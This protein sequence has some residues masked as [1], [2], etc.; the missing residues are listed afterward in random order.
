MNCL[1]I[2]PNLLS[3][4]IDRSERYTNYT[5]L[6]QI[7]EYN[8]PIGIYYDYFSSIEGFRLKN[9][10]NRII[11]NWNR[12]K[13]D[14][15]EKEEFIN[16]EYSENEYHQIHANMNDRE[17]ND[18]LSDFCGHNHLKCFFACNIIQNSISPK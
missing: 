4:K 15:R 9:I 3:K 12:M 16:S 7:K 18:L 10:W 6:D 14:L 1:W 8:L 2:D 17:F 11:I 5:C 13:Y